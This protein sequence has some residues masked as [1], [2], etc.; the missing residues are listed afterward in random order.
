MTQDHSARPAGVRAVALTLLLAACTLA[1]ATVAGAQDQGAFQLETPSSVLTGIGADVT[2]RAPADA[3]GELT[4]LVGDE[5]YTATIGADGSAGFSGVAFPSTE[6]AVSL[7]YQGEPAQLAQ[8]GGTP[9]DTVTV[10]A[11][12]GF[13]SILAP[14]IAIGLALLTRRVIP[15]LV[16]GV[17]VGA[18]FAADLSLYGIWAGLLDV[19]DTW[20][21]RALVPADGG[22]GHMSI[23]L[24]TMMIGGM[25]G[26]IYRNG[27]A[28]AIVDRL[29][30]WASNRRRGEIA[31]AGV[32]TAIFFDDY[33]SLL[34]TGNAVRPMTDRLRI[35]REKLAYYVDTSAAPI[36]TLALVSTWIG[37][38]V[39]LI[40][41]A[42]AGLEGFTGS[43]YGTFLGALPYMFYPILAFIFMWMLAVSGRDFG[44]M[45]RAQ[46]RALTGDLSEA[47][48]ED[49]GAEEGLTA[50]QDIPHRAVNA[51]V[52][53]LVL[54]GVTIAALFVTGSGDTLTDIIGSADSFSALLWGSLLSVLVAGVLSVSQGVL[55]LGETVEAWLAGIKSVLEVLVILTL[56]WALS[57]V[58]ED[59]QAAAY[60][61]DVLGEAIP[62][63]ILPALVF[64][65]AAAIA[66]ATGTSWGTMGI[67][68]PL[69][70]PLTWAILG[71]QGMANEAG[72]LV[73]HASVASVLAGAVW[74]DHTSPISDTTVLASATSHCGVV[75]HANTQLPY[76]L[77]VGAI[78]LVLGLLPAG[79]GAPWWVGLVLCIAAL[80][81]VL[82]GVARPIREHSHAH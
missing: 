68:L 75:E 82:Y 70:V 17:W 25:V 76:G 81:G 38:Q 52:P 22:T 48:G 20:V 71:N 15:S 2:V 40:G 3:S 33:A 49:Q 23:L 28:Q 11:I 41:D 73:L 46:E 26:I 53:V 9:A 36:A 5:R 57:A 80:F 66:F 32:G 12:P 55:S 31:S 77:V 35:S 61:A 62:T 63:W 7:Q 13:L 14:I 65:L 51:V 30:G 43:A 44:P 29:T 47:R 69:A 42:T 4:L 74:G 10:Q 56:A 21:L 16:A 79:F 60:L 37:F 18:W 64:V 72:M 58:T 1:W 6:T 45:A 34:V 8:A 67:L 39:G 27:G 54:L 50:K 78:A 24:F 59:L 19:V